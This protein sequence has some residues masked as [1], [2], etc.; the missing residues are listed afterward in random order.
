MNYIREK[1][2][3][4]K[5]KIKGDAYLPIVLVVVFLIIVISIIMIRKS[6]QAETAREISISISKKG[7]KFAQHKV[8]VFDTISHED[9]WKGKISVNHGVKCCIKIPAKEKK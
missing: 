5:K 3:N 7:N 1:K 4:Y 9:I 8:R 6:P 2:K